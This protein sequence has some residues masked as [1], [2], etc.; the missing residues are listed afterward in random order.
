MFPLYINESP[1]NHPGGS[2]CEDRSGRVSRAGQQP[3]SRIVRKIK[4]AA[5]AGSRGDRERELALTPTGGV[6]VSR[7]AAGNTG[8]TFNIGGTS[9][10]AIGC[11]GSDETSRQA[12]SLGVSRRETGSGEEKE[13]PRP[14]IFP[15]F[16]R[17]CGKTRKG[18]GSRYD[19]RPRRS[20]CG[21]NCRQSSR[22]GKRWHRRVVENGKWLCSA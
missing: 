1:H 6:T 22:L 14:S 5:E 8:L 19:G 7:P 2:R 21:A 3:Q 18:N 10:V 4:L 15:G 13:S 9:A 17:S 20:G 11:G 16:R 12:M